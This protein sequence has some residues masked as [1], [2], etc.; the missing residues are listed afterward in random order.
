MFERQLPPTKGEHLWQ[1]L[2]RDPALPLFPVGATGH[3][4]GAAAGQHGR[5]VLV[6]S[7]LADLTYRCCVIASRLV[8]A[9]LMRA[10]RY[11]TRI[12]CRHSRHPVLLDGVLSPLNLP[13]AA[14]SSH[15]LSGMDIFR[16]CMAA[17]SCMVGS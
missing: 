11:V 17:P 5:S 14:R 13:R 7:V 6:R 10:R 16:A 4:R 8:E 1:A 15:T 2:G 9:L 3:R 12:F